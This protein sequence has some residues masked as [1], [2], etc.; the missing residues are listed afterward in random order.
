VKRHDRVGEHLLGQILGAAMV[1]GTPTQI[2]VHL[3]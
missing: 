2:A 3:P 1:A